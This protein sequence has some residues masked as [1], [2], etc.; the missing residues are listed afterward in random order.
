VLWAAFL[1]YKWAIAEYGD[2]AVELDALP[3]PVLTDRLEAAIRE[4]MDL[5]ALEAVK[6]LEARERD[7]LRRAL[8]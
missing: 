5:E 8:R 4:R 1:F 3:P 2:R 6:S 7:Q